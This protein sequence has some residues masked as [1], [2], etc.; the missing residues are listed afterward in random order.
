M[1]RERSFTRALFHGVISEDLVL[2]YPE[3]STREQAPLR[4]LLDDIRRIGTT[5]VDS[6]E[7]DRDQ[8]IG[9]DLLGELKSLGLFGL[10]VPEEHGG[11]GLSTTACTRVIEELASI[12]QS[13]AATIGTHQDMAVRGLEH[14]GNETQKR[15]Y[16]PRL[17]SGEWIGAFALTEPR[18]GNDI[19]ALETRADLARDGEGYVLD[20]NK[21]WVTNGALADLFVVF[22]RSG[23]AE[24]G[25]RPRITAFLVERSFGAGTGPEEPKL[26]VRG[27]STTALYLE[28]IKV[29]STNLL[30]EEGRGVAVTMHILDHSRLSLAA[31]CVGGSKAL[32]RTVVRRCLERR[33]FGRPIAKFEMV[34][35]KVARMMCRL[36]A[37]ESMTYL[38]T[39]LVDT[40]MPDC[41]VEAAICKVF[42]SETYWNVAHE[43]LQIAGGR[44]YMSEHPYER[45][46]RN[47]RLHLIVQGTNEVLRAYIAL[48]G[49]QGP[50][51]QVGGVQRALQEPLS[52]LGALGD[53]AVQR[54]KNA[55]GRERMEGVH[56]AL[57][58]E[59][60]LFE[61]SVSRLS[62]ETDRILRKHGEGV[63]DKQII[64][65][66]IADATIDLYALAAVLARTTR[67]VEARGEE[68]AR[69]EMDLACGFALLARERL[70][71][72][73]GEV[74][75]EED[76]VLR[77]VATQT[78]ADGGYPFDATR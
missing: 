50:S 60:V 56:P 54:A 23:G 70:G 36:Y 38:T 73:L 49:L 58:K 2:P 69:R 67:A 64:L 52:A 78:Y 68:G 40:S 19:F 63:A 10:A 76:E 12:D 77:Q 75:R 25:A 4:A 18:T 1:S 13:V 34:A 15:R 9:D 14:F 35:D 43:C 26:G 17:A 65:K 44:G 47:A 3:L 27:T 20:G 48:S 62:R 37:L 28:R 59:S 51:K 53:F 29:P 57:K 30:A 8:R 66:R 41:S 31:S 24:P 45:A 61:E 11:K 16:L 39:A 46:L 6:A 71:D 32:L 72:N 22:A 21:I 33:A 55:F 42:G 5:Q 74:D 7:I